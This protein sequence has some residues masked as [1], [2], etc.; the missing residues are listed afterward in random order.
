ML[1]D[2]GK[3]V[4][5]QQVLADLRDLAL[6]SDDLDELLNALFTGFDDGGD[7]WVVIASLIQT[8]K[9]NGVAPEAW[10]ADTL[11]R[12]AAGHP[13]TALDALMPWRHA[14]TVG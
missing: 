11:A 6:R 8:A 7:R 1:P 12:L 14:R 9:L 10:L 3:M 13:A 5:R 2:N 4:A